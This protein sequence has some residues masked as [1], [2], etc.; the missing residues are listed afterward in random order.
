MPTRLTDALVRPPR[1][2]A[3][4]GGDYRHGNSHP[5]TERHRADPRGCRV[6]GAGSWLLGNQWPAGR[7]RRRGRTYRCACFSASSLV[8]SYNH[9]GKKKAKMRQAGQHGQR[10]ARTPLTQAL[11]YTKHGV[12]APGVPYWAIRSKLH[13][14]DCFPFDLTSWHSVTAY[15]PRISYKSTISQPSLL[16]NSRPFREQ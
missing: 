4:Q 16:R 2:R 12:T 15:H 14:E 7:V 1:H 9:K 8:F 5:E 11:V 3:A 13:W 6:R 10:A